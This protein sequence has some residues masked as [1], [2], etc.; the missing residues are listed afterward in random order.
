MAPNRPQTRSGSMSQMGQKRRF[1]PLPAASSLLR[2]TDIIRP[3]RLVRFVPIADIT[4]CARACRASPSG[5]AVVQIGTT[6]KSTG[7]PM[8]RRPSRQRA[9]L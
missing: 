3:V 7:T 5:L 8:S 6:S 9:A 2:T 4:R 1:D